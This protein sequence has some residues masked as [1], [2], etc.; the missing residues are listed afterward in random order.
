MP[1]GR[2]EVMGLVPSSSDFTLERA[3]LH[4]ASLTFTQYKQGRAVFR[5]EAVR[6]ELLS[7]DRD[8]WS[9]GFRV[10]YGPWP[11]TAWLDS[12]PD[13]QE[14]NRDMAEEDDLPAPAEV[15]AG[16]PSRLSVS[17]DPDDP[18]YD[19]SERFSEYTDQLRERFEVFI[20]DDV[21][22]GCRT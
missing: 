9:H 7:A 2:Y 1:H 5:N 13:V 21:N 10:W 15:I 22:G 4:F 18:D 16:C 11:V 20:H 12:G 8:S 14:A 17:S 3:V 19:N 6:A